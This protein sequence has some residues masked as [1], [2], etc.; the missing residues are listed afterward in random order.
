MRN[1]AFALAAL[2][3]SVCLL[4]GSVAISHAILPDRVASHF[5]A[6]GTPNRWTSRS[7]YTLELGSLGIG[8]PALLVGVFYS[9][10]FF[11]PSLI[12]LPQRDYWLAPERCRETFAVLFRS[13]LWLAC[14][15]SL[16]IVGIQILL[17]AA[18]RANPVRLSSAAWVLL[19][20][21]LVGVAAWIIVFVRRFQKCT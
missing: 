15:E 14:F 8:L 16:F 20:G 7:R 12:N 21:F 13:G 2:G 9:V 6:S 10:R 3:L 18:N 19:A 5:D 17:V 11:P 1:N 4:L